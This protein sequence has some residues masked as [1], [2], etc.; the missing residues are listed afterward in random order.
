MTGTA[1]LPRALALQLIRVA[2]IRAQYEHYRIDAGPGANFGPAIF[3]MTNS[4]NR[5]VEAIGSGDIAAQL[6]ALKD[7]EEFSE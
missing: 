7:L 5:A 3:L 6:R 4:L 1:S 2:A